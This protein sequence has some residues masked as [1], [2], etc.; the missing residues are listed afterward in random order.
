MATPQNECVEYRLKRFKE[1]RGPHQIGLVGEAAEQIDGGGG[2]C[3]CGTVELRAPLPQEHLEQVVCA[4]P[5]GPHAG[6][7]LR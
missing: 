3:F 2:Y 5:G 6:A 7:A 1:E 4:T